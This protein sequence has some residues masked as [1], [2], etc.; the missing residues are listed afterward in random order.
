MAEGDR[1]PIDGYEPTD[2]PPFAVTVDLVILTVRPPR[3]EVLLVERTEPPFAG[4][5]ALPGGFVGPDETLV[6][7]AR[8]KLSEKTGVLV[9]RAHLEQ[10]ASFGA[11]DRDPRMRVVSVAYLAMTAD[12]PSPTPAADAGRAEWI[13]IATVDRAALAFDHGQILDAG[14]ERA[15]AKLEYST[16]ATSFCGS[17]FT[18][19]ELRSVYEAVWGVP[20]DAPNFHRK[21]MATD[22]FV[23]PT[24]ETVAPAK[25][26]PA[27]TYRAGPATELA[28]PLQ[29]SAR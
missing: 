22:G 19:G 23:E 15:R 6:E 21:V 1:S 16:L 18:I 9:D 12:P 27:K 11:V 26:R 4:R 28:P 25:G 8:R 13:D 24:G 2:F 7:A 3:V 20:L 29:R 17:T 14:L 5:L 10:L